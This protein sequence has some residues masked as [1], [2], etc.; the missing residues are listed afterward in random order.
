MDDRPGQKMVRD[1]LALVY[2][3]GYLDNL[4]SLFR[5]ALASL[6]EGLS[7]HPSVGPSVGRSVGPSVRW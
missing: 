7:V 4:L 5:C 1:T 6:Y 3:K 2:D